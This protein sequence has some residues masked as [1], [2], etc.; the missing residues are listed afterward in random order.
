MQ[1]NNL[2]CTL[3]TG[4]FT[5]ATIAPT[6][7]ESSQ[8]VTFRIAEYPDGRQVVQGAY[9]WSCGFTGGVT[10]RDLPKVLVDETGQEVTYE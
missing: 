8:P 6:R 2:I 5:A 3:P 4:P 7:T 1:P 10:W 9:P